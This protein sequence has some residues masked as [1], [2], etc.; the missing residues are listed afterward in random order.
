MNQT[1]KNAAVYTSRK[2]G[3]WK[4]LFL[5]GGPVRLGLSSCMIWPPRSKP[6]ARSSSFRSGHGETTGPTVKKTLVDNFQLFP[7]SE[8]E[9]F[10]YL[11]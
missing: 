5:E 7:Y 2:N 6:S 1:N 11:L 4:N 3:T 10:Y 9:K 8:R